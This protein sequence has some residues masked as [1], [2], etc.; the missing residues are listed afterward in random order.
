MISI[1]IFI[2]GFII[3]S[4]LGLKGKD[5]RA[6]DLDLL[7]EWAL[8]G[9]RFGAFLVWFLIGADLFTA[10]TFIAV[11]AGIFAK[12]PI[13]FFAVP[14]V[15]I[16]FGVALMVMP[17]FFSVS[18]EKCHITAV[19]FVKDLYNSKTLAILVAIIGILAEL[20]YIALQMVG[21]KVVLATM[22]MQFKNIDQNLANE[23]ALSLAFLIL[24]W[25]TYKSGLRGATLTA[26]LK[27]FLII[28]TVIVLAVYIPFHY[29]G[30][31]E[32]FNIKKEYATLNPKLYTAYISLALMSA[33]ALFLYPH[34]I[35]GCLSSEDVKVLKKAVA[36]LPIYGIGLAILAMFGILVYEVKP[37]M[38]ILNHIS[39]SA[40][41]SFVVPVLI[42]STMPGWFSG[43]ALL[44]VFI[45]GLVPASIMAIASAN[46]SVNILRE[47]NLTS[48]STE[49][50]LAKWF[51]FL[52]KLI[53]LLLVFLVPPTFAISFQLIGGIIILQT[54]PSVF[55]GLFIKSL[56]KESLIIGLVVGVIV[57]IYELEKVNHFGFITSVLMPSFLGP[58]FIGVLALFINLIIV[59]VG[60]FITNTFRNRVQ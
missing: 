44:G 39:A 25:F 30:F 15:A 7:H 55:L 31:H 54:L 21:M 60:S 45:G 57:G 18:K 8:G 10:Y 48:S 59:F 12:G 37:A 28:G 2:I 3:F 34:A 20:P 19:D 58:I 42:N 27:D 38:E 23:I 41:G 22:L 51:S 47:L 9:Q 52:F 26:I 5:F 46:L 4:Y 43:I 36:F 50:K 17:K 11:P 35:T 6:G 40:R 33:L 49:T 29:H 13:F 14:Y 1:A 53:P 56:N 16:G 32:A 24:S